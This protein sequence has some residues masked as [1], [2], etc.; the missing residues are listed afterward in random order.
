MVLLLMVTLL[1]FCAAAAICSWRY[2][3]DEGLRQE[4]VQLIRLFKDSLTSSGRWQAAFA[5]LEPPI[6]QKLAS[7]CGVS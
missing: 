7:M 4:M 5:E 1:L 6:Q 2:C 3:A